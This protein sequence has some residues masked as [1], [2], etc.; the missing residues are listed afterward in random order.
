MLF[1]IIMVSVALRWIPSPVFMVMGG[2]RLTESESIILSMRF[3]LIAGCIVTAPIFLVAYTTLCIARPMQAAYR[4]GARRDRISF[5][6]W[7]A[8]AASWLVWLLVL[9]ATQ[10]EQRLRYQAER[11]IHGGDV[12][13]LCQLARSHAMSDFPPHWDPPP[14]IGYGEREPE[15]IQLMLGI[16]KHA[17]PPWLQQILVEKMSAHV[18]QLSAWYTPN[19]LASLSEPQLAALLELISLTDDIQWTILSE[20]ID[21]ELETTSISASSPRIASAAQ[22]ASRLIPGVSQPRQGRQRANVTKSLPSSGSHFPKT[23]Q[24]QRPPQKRNVLRWP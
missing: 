11:A 23:Q 13:Q 20:A 6:V 1:S 4:P 19:S 16:F 8:M 12:A 24:K 10:A 2:V 3:L 21:R 22:A 7:S 15:L 17:P 18:E 9:P 5:G 14:R